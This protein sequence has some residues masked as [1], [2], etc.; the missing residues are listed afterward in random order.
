MD[1]KNLIPQH[2][3]SSWLLILSGIIFVP[4]GLLYTGRAIWKWPA[5]QSKGYLYLE[6]GLVVAAILVAALGLVL[7]ERLLE[8][9]GDDIL[10]PL[11]LVIFLIGTVLV[12][13][14]E[15]FSISGQVQVY[16]LIAVFVVLIFLGQAVFGAS[17]LRTGILPAWVGWTTVIWNL[18]W[19]VI[20]PITRPQ[21]MYYP[22]LYYVAPELIGIML[23][24]V[25][26]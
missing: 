1:I 9:A 23:L 16:A 4:G 26:R 12:I 3:V 17:I 21:D 10:A 15:A 2:I 6:R 13:T 19:L 24:L 14:A 5:A 7:L 22:W 25:R 20:L 18:A 8:A 11:G